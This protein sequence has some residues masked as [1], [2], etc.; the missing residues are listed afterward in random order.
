[1]KRLVILIGCVVL[2]FLSRVSV[3]AEPDLIIPVWPQMAPGE[4]GDIGPEAEVPRNDPIKTTRIT[5]ISQPTLQLWRP[6]PEKDC[7]T[8]VI[9][10]PG[11]GYNY[12]VVDKEGSEVAAWLNSLGV[13][14][15]VLKYR[16]P[17]RKDRPKHEAPLQDAQRAVSLLRHRAKELKLN[18]DRIGILGLSAGGQVAALC[19]TH[20]EKLTYPLIDD[21]D[22]AGSRPDFSM[23]LY[24]AYLA[25]KETGQ[26]AADVPV[27]SKT[28][29]AFLMMTQDDGLGV[30]SA[31]AY[32]LAL[33]RAKVPAEMHLY[34]TGGHG[35][36]MRLEP[37]H[38][39][40][41]WPARAEDWLRT[42][43]W[44]TRP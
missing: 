10:C 20:F 41:S 8:T 18:P 35:Y 36:G 14:G 26:L 27:S 4:K 30:E 16:V 7:G 29:S 24:P 38:T 34:P 31:V 22:R 5:S 21:A 12:V 1:M 6:K 9:I 33:K 40:A 19:S 3:A 42:G 11:G 13:T 39:A 43:G 15:A 32:Y 37:V 44:L 23:L 28:P 25:D 2:P 17:V